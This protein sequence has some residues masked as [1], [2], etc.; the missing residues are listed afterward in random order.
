MDKPGAIGFRQKAIADFRRPG[1]NHFAVGVLGHGQ[2]WAIAGPLS[3][4][5]KSAPNHL[6]AAKKPAIKQ[7]C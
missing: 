7:T 2:N 3:T 5:V 1:G 4:M 6:F